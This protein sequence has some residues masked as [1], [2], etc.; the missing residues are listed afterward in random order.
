MPKTNQ[1]SVSNGNIKMGKIP[2]IS[3]PAIVTC[4][5]DCKCC[6][7]CYAAKIERL[8]SSVKAAYLHNLQMLKEQPETFWRQAEAVIMLSRYFRFHVSGDIP[9]REYLEKMVEISAKQSH[10]EIL[11]FTKKFDIVNGFLTAG[12]VIPSNLHLIFSGWKDLVMENPFHLPEA[13]VLYKD[14]TTTARPDAKKCGG[15]CTECARTGVG[16]WVLEKGE[17]VVLDEH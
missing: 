3:L 2:S 9:D 15:N 13:H 17:Q 8:R 4:R 5:K 11:C 12:G 6:K 7:K 16:C 14:G 1:I 10:C